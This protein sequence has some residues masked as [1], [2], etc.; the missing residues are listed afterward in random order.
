MKFRRRVKFWIVLYFVYSVSVW[1]IIIAVHKNADSMHSGESLRSWFSDYSIQLCIVGPPITMMGIP[2]Y[3]AGSMALF[4]VG[5]NLFLP[6]Q[7]IPRWI[8]FPTMGM[9]WCLGGLLYQVMNA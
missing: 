5:V 7:N 9:V 1:S 3:I 6:E 8:S 2:Y 4:I